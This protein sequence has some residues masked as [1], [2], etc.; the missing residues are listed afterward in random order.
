MNQKIKRK[1]QEKKQLTNMEGLHLIEDLMINMNNKKELI[2][3]IIK[4]RAKMNQ[5][6]DMKISQLI[7]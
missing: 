6:K 7:I 1:E 2:V 4:E 5:E 3:M